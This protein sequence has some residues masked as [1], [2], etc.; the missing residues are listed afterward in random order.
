MRTPPR[1]V[2]WQRATPQRAAALPLLLAITAR[3]ALAAEPPAE[4]T[5]VFVYA[6]G[7][8]AALE[9]GEAG[10]DDL[11]RWSEVCRLPCEGVHVSRTPPYRVAGQAIL[12][13]DPFQLLP[14]AEAQV[15]T[16]RATTLSNRDWAKGLFIGGLVGVGVGAGLL[17]PAFILGSNPPNSTASAS[18]VALFGVGV[19]AA[20]VGAALA[21]IG[22]I[23]LA[24]AKTTVNIESRPAGGGG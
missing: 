16:V 11:S 8:D 3:P 20:V 17:I 14:G 2:V 13:S 19:G 4:T 7:S 6:D 9:R 24:N 10:K 18:T 23:A 12:A 15:V 21:V 1:A 22:G 5:T